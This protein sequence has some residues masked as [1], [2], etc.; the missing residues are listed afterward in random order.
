MFARVFRR[1]GRSPAT[2]SAFPRDEGRPGGIPVESERRR[3]PRS[4][5]TLPSMV[6]L[7]VAT[8]PQAADALIVPEDESLTL[9]EYRRLG[10]PDASQPWSVEQSADALVALASLKRIELPRYRSDRSHL[11]FERLVMTHTR[12]SEGTLDTSE[13]REGE[14][15]PRAPMVSLPVLYSVGKTDQF[16]FD[17]E[18]VAIRGAELA[19]SLDIFPSRRKLEDDLEHFR[20]A[21]ADREPEEAQALVAKQME[22][23]DSIARLAA[24]VIIRQTSN[25]LL[26]AAVKDVSPAAR[27]MLAE[28]VDSFVARLLDVL[29]AEESRWV[30]TMIRG[31]ASSEFNA[32]IRPQLLSA[33]QILEKAIAGGR[34][35]DVPK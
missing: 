19:T 23:Y 17:R 6:A 11:L 26:I 2:E 29:S 18:L 27:S 12:L 13:R 35:S 28:R 1:S 14:D 30:A 31:A 34:E 5:F 8:V 25:L 21:T 33:V 3:V 4:R 10:V 16:L 20:H 7:F 15:A 24:Q 9:T 32:E 22:R